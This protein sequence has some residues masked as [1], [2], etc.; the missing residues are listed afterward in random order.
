MEIGYKLKKDKWNEK[1]YSQ[2]VNF[3][4]SSDGKAII[5]E[6]EDCYEI[7][8]YREPTID[9]QWQKIDIDKRTDE[10]FLY[11]NLRYRFIDD[12]VRGHLDLDR[13]LIEVKQGEILTCDECLQKILFY[14]YDSGQS[15]K[16]V[17]YTE[18]RMRAKEYVRGVSGKY[19]NFIK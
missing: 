7:T 14:T 17:A 6:R 3:C 2:M 16:A 4:N 11:E 9:E 10:K 12:N 19:M 13:P 1:D 18:A 5:T 8:E 15:D